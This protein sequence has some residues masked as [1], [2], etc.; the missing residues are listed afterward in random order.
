[1]RLRHLIEDADRKEGN[2]CVLIETKLWDMVAAALVTKN[3][4]RCSWLLCDQDLTSLA[5]SLFFFFFLLFLL[6]YSFY[7]IYMSTL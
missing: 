3:L 2:Q 5:R 4:W 6:F 7:V 1:M